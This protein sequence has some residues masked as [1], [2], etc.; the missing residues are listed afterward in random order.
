MPM[1]LPPNRFAAPQGSPYPYVGPNYMQHREVSGYVYVPQ[2]DKYYLD[3]RTVEEKFKKQGIIKKPPG[4]LEEATPLVAATAGAAAAK[5]I[6]SQVGQGKNPFSGLLDF[7]GGSSG[8]A[9]AQPEV[10]SETMQGGAPTAATAATQPL[11][12]MLDP[13]TVSSPMSA[14][15]TGSG[16]FMSGEAPL[17]SMPVAQGALGGA[18]LLHGGYGMFEA[19]QNNNPIGGAMSGA[20]A[21]LGASML[22]SSLGLAV[23]GVGWMIAG[24]MLLGAGAGFLGKIGDKDMWKTEGD[25]LKKLSESGAF[26]PPDM[27]SSL[28]TQGRSKEELQRTDLPDDFVGFDQNG[29][30]AN[31]KFNQSRNEADLKGPDIV[32][33]ST[34]AE[35]DPNWYQ[36]PLEERINYAQSVLDAGAVRE[37]H[38]TVDVDFSKAPP[39][40]W[41]QEQ[42][43]GQNQNG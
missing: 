16:S 20:E 42:Q 28:P 5:E 13:A 15:P 21:G 23:P 1:S 41:Q 7:G 24:G 32:N 29:V 3:P 17:S 6:G 10:I 30:W 34:F 26:I 40:P 12:G 19:N 22:A 4:L 27:L 38:G 18:A 2:E 11:P 39:M 37:H 14:P 31:N 35:K 9:P 36:R 25:R 43:Q 8:A 33:Y